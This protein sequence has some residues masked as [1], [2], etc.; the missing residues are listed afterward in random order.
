MAAHNVAPATILPALEQSNRQSQSG[1]FSSG[2]REYLV[3]TGGFLRSSEELG[4][5]VIGVFNE[6]LVYLRDVAKIEDGPEEPADYVMFGKGDGATKP[7]P[8]NPQSAQPAVTISV[9]KRKGVNAIEIADK[10]LEKFERL[11]GSLIPSEVTVTTTRNYGETAS[12]KSNELLLHIMIAI[13]SV[14][15]LIWLTLGLRESGVVVT[16]IPVT[17]AL[18]LTVFYFYGY[19]LNRITLF[20]LIFSIG[21]LVDDAVVVVENIARHSRLPENKGR[22]IRDVAVEAVDEVGNPTI[23]ATFAVIAAILPMAF[24]GG[25][26]GPYMKPIPVGATA[27]LLF[28]LLVAFIVTPWAS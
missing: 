12:E 6:R 2:N 14:A 11:K 17:L 28:S 15:A 16:A 21:I 5:V 23:L 24:V 8:G 20:A 26:M 3:E 25:L 22:P 27:A 18:T 13:F 7:E 9:A 1:G 4:A 10:V 19:T